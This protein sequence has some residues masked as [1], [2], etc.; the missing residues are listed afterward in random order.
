MPARRS[1]TASSEPSSPAEPLAVAAQLGREVLGLDRERAQPLG[2]RVEAGVDARERVQTCGAGGDQLG[3]AEAGRAVLGRERVGRCAGGRAAASRGARGGARAAS[4]SLVLVL[5]EAGG[6]DLREL[7][8]EQIELA[9]TRRG[10]LAQGLELRG[11]APGLRE[12]LR[13][14]RAGAARARGR[15]PASRISSCAPASVSLRCSCWP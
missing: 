14:R 2:E 13:R 5:V 7:V 4:S 10:E 6:V 3:A 15:R 8:L 1:S 12:R 9:L 11:E